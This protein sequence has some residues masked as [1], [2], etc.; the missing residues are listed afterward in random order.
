MGVSRWSAHSEQTTDLCWLE[1]AGQLRLVSTGLDGFV[2]YHSVDGIETCAL[3]SGDALRCIDS[4]DGV[5]FAGGEAGMLRTWR[6]DAADLHG[7][8][9]LGE[10]RSAGELQ[11]VAVNGGAGIVAAGGS[12]G[13]VRVFS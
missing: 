1:I 8:Q 3:A 7:M 13:M 9:S 2:R 10:R 6:A 11:C 4:Y 5:L 12:D